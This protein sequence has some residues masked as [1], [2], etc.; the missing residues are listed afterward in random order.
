ME[1]ILEYIIEWCI[2]LAV[3][4]IP[5]TLLL[6]RE[7]LATFNRWLLI[8]IIAISAILPAIEIRIPVVKE[9]ET[10]EE[11]I[12]YP[13]TVASY[14][15]YEATGTASDDINGTKG[16]RPQFTAILKEKLQDPRTYS[17]IYIIGVILSATF[18]VRGIIGIRR[19]IMYGTLWREKRG[20]MTIHCHANEIEPFSWFGE[21]A[22]S[23][24]DYNE[25]GHEILLHEEGHIR[26]HH[27]WDMLFIR[28]VK[29]LQWFNPFVY[30]LAN[31]MREI[32]E[33]EADSYVLSRYNDA[34]A[35][36]LL[37]LKKATAKEKLGLANSFNNSNVRHR[38]EMMVRGKANKARSFK[39][40][41]MLPIIAVCIAASAKPEY[42]Y[43]YTAPQHT[44]SAETESHAMAFPEEEVI[45]GN[46]G[47]YGEN[48]VIEPTQPIPGTGVEE[49]GMCEIET[50]QSAGHSET[51]SR[52]TALAA[53]QVTATLPI[54]QPQAT[55]TVC[56]YI[57]ITAYTGNTS[58]DG[59]NVLK[60]NSSVIFVCGK[61]GKAHEIR[62][63]G[64]SI[65]LEGGEC[66]GSKLL[67][68]LN[69]HFTA[70]V[71][72]YVATRLW[73]PAIID[74]KEVETYIEAHIIFH[75]GDAGHASIGNTLMV[76]STLIE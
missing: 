36:Q 20:R 52:V 35:Y 68:E 64:N 74:G 67:S 65:V 60:C 18:A 12:A 21:V 42:I 48:S 13:S 25:C 59:C 28:C 41:Y 24:R 53:E 69:E 31:D 58:S 22:I 43:N 29:A 5:F 73:Q 75:K 19:R 32:H 16:E 57:D 54:G 15:G 51:I 26:R 30:M 34:K 45:A 56:E 66:S 8:C 3:L 70:A 50:V 17:Y 72:D 49:K 10:I 27:S 6:R 71:K 11:R 4:Y 62:N 23:E 40:I 47:T 9:I 1:A 46:N 2:Y 76:G 63:T 33:Y 37:I 55:R 39:A 61:N 7:N 38:I 14:D 44:A